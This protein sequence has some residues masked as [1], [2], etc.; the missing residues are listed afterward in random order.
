MTDTQTRALTTLRDIDA[1]LHRLFEAVDDV[2][3]TAATPGADPLATLQRARS[4]I[5]ATLFEH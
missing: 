5:D 4:Q 3:G 2:N 1:R